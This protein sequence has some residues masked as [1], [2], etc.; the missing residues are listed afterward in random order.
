MTCV[1]MTES[2][3]ICRML[4]VLPCHHS[5]FRY[6]MLSVFKLNV[7]LLSVIIPNV[8]MLHVIILNV[9]MQSFI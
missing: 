9:V 7:I 1:R 2:Q 8:F 4:K 6:V 5:S 3:L